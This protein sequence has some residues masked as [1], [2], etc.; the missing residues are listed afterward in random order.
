MLE[1]I[2]QDFN[3]SN[4]EISVYKACLDHGPL[5]ASKIAQ[6]TKIKRCPM[7]YDRKADNN[8]KA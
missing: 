2:L 3:L 8:R 4:K 5:L 1:R 7:R 6:I